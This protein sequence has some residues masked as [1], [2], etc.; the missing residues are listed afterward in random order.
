MIL[1]QRPPVEDLQKLGIPFQN[2]VGAS[3]KVNNLI[4]ELSH[5]NIDWKTAVG[6]I[7]SYLFD[8][9]HE[10]APEGPDILPI[11]FYFLY[12]ATARK[13]GSALRACETFFNR[14]NFIIKNRGEG[15]GAFEKLQELF[16]EFYEKYNS[17]LLE[18][19][20]QGYFYGSI[21]NT[22]LNF[23]ST[24]VEKGEEAGPLLAKI[25]TFIKLQFLVYLER[26]ILT[27]EKEIKKLKVSL[28]GSSVRDEI[29]DL[30]E[31]VSKKS[32]RRLLDS[33]EDGLKKDQL[34]LF[35]RIHEKLD[36]SHNS[37]TWEKI[38][39]LV[40]KSIDEDG[41]DDASALDLLAYLI[42]K[43][44]EGSDRD[45]QLF[46]SRTVASV[47]STF[48]QKEKIS[49]LNDV[50]DMV[51]PSLL[52][53]IE[54]ERNYYAAFTTIYN[55]GKTVIE[56]GNLEVID[57]FVDILVKSKFCFPSFSGIASDWSVIVN[58]SHLE[59]IRTWMKLIELNPVL[60]GRLAASLIVNLKLGGVF[61]K[62]TDVFQR[63]ISL[64]LNSDYKEAFYLVTSLAAVFP[65]FFHDIG[66]TGNIRSFTEKIDTNHQMNDLIHFVRKQVHVESSSRTVFLV[67]RVVEFWLSGD[68]TLLKGLVPVEVYDNLDHLYKMIN[69]DQEKVPEEIIRE[70][71]EHFTHLA[72]LK[73]WDFLDQI[74]RDTFVEFV[75]KNNFRKI[76]GKE[77]KE[78]LIYFEDYF[79]TRNPTELSKMLLVIEDMFGVDMTTTKI[80]KLLYEISDDE[81]RRMFDVVEQC[82]VSKVNV[83]KFITFLHVYRMLFDKY[84]FSEIR[85]VE[86]LEIYAGEGLF[87]PHE[88]FFRVLTGPDLLKALDRLLLTQDSL[89][90]GILLSGEQ[91]EPLDTIEFKRHIAFGIPSMYGSYKEKKFD[92][93]KVF[94]HM[95][96]I[97]LSLFE[98][99]DEE[100][101][102]FEKGELDFPL[103]R[104][105]IF[106]FLRTF[107]IDGLANQEMLISCNL[108][109]TPNMRFAQFRDIINH[110]LSI[111]GEVSDRFNKTFKSVCVSAINNIGIDS[112]IE[113]FHPHDREN[114]IEIIVD[115]FMRDQIMQSPLLQ[116][117]DNFLIRLRDR[118][119]A[120]M[121]EKSDFICLNCGDPDKLES[122]KIHELRSF[123]DFMPEHKT[124]L[125]IWDIGGK[126]YSL[127]FARNIKELTV[128]D[129]FILPPGLY[130][131]I[132]EGDINSSKFREKVVDHFR[133][134]IDEFSE[135]RFGNPD[136][137]MLF[138]VRSGA[139]FSMP[140]VMDTIT[141]VGMTDEILH[142]LARRDMWFAYDC[143]RRLIQDFAISLA[144]VDRR[145]FENLMATAKGRAGVALKEQL[146]GEQMRDVAESYKYAINNYA[147]SLPKDPYLQLLYA[148]LSVYKSWDSSIARNYRKFINISDEWGTSVVVQKMVFG[149]YTPSCLTGVVHSSF[150]GSENIGIFGEYKTR[151]QGYDIV[152][153]VARVFPI[154]ERQKT[155][156][157]KLKEYPSL[158]NSFPEIYKKLLDMVATVRKHWKNDVEMEFTVQNDLLYLLQVRGMTSDTFDVEEVDEKPRELIKSLLGQGL[159]ASGG[160]VSGRAVFDIDRIDMVRNAYPGDKLVLIR[161]E[162]NPEDVIG[163]KKSDGILTCIGGM[164]SHAVL[165]M[166]RLNKSGVSDFSA[167]KID[168]KKNIAV[169]KGGNE[170]DT[171]IIREGDFLTIDGST[172]HVYFGFHKT[173]KK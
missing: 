55:I 105:I 162:T 38:C 28:A 43:S 104:E 107:L 71:K 20:R 6:E 132:R 3:R 75:E 67:Q 48:V 110:L 122:G 83:E 10:I 18:E 68:R 160:A 86:K 109:D 39:T 51:M 158:E 106:L 94:F 25:N 146:S 141:N 130:D 7:R 37:R 78:A 50:V 49:L 77:K 128:P 76:S 79:T 165:Q 172:G 120:E 136:N 13:K 40:R 22:V 66:A 61:L 138:S 73:F 96:L 135:G 26:I 171:T 119:Q 155:V 74:G 89:K 108:L 56:S 153:G 121:D 173:K 111:H 170:D 168:D 100:Y 124:Y 143:Y 113:K 47:C 82:D 21:N 12:E 152:S 117:F 69:Y 46:I 27:S 91:F 98:K 2:K 23:G 17:L 5:P 163:M 70:M 9:I 52:R 90:K 32:Y 15:K 93:L 11:L 129:G 139:V 41:I 81:F 167:M 19:S 137:P 142:R 84:N 140:G 54:N 148:I 8:Y 80:W 126:A 14:Y 53:E 118:V 145:V 164:T 42:E 59:N 30:L 63:D 95:N 103:I 45:L 85:A 150:H 151:A 159:A 1:T 99:I 131:W 24:L 156:Q 58:S 169:I 161:P 64:L 60:M 154:S 114:S 34:G 166:K 116:L 92:T 144:D 88:D 123:D 102:N 97:R 87:R 65:A 133:E 44:N 16:D 35:G 33:V 31:S 115:R 127:F 134:Y 36:F 57:Y 4:E 62:D 29:L 157:P 125:P 112:I 101:G 149:N 147:V 72:D